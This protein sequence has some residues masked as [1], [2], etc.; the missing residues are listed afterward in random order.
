MNIIVA[1]DQNW[2]IG[3]NG[4]LLF[5]ISE[6]LKRFR[7]LTTGHCVVYGRKT[8]E[9]FP[10]GKPLPNRDNVVITSNPDYQ[11]DAMVAHNFDELRRIVHDY[12]T[13]EVDI[14]GGA[15]IY[16]QLLPYCDTAY[17]TK[18]DADTKEADAFFPNLDIDPHWELIDEG[19]IQQSDEHQYR[20]VTYHNNQPL[21][22]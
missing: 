5:H 2:A 20:F 8:L 15:S 16:E 10:E 18:I 1:V 17:V 4:Q 19:P 14:I 22:F 7:T 21:D 9:T 3:K 6:D 12:P 11:V 13:T